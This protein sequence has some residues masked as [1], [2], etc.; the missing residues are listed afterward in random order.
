MARLAW[1]TI[2]QFLGSKANLPPSHQICFSVSPCEELDEASGLALHSC[3]LVGGCVKEPPRK[4]LDSGRYC[5][6]PAFLAWNSLSFAQLS[7]FYL[8]SV[9]ER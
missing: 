4:L 1:P 6:F 7:H 8:F 9:G 3:Q 2:P 5:L